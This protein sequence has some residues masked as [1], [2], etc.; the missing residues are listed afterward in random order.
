[1]PYVSVMDG[2]NKP[3]DQ[4]SIHL[5]FLLWG[6]FLTTSSLLHAYNHCYF[7]LGVANTQPGA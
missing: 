6:E 4:D 2:E 3:E 5:A 1:M 7:P